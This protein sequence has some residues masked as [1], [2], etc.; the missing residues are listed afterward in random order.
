MW[1]GGGFRGCGWCG[2][3]VRRWFCS[4]APLNVGHVVG[5]FSRIC[6]AVNEKR[7]IN[8]RIY[9]STLFVNNQKDGM[10]LLLLLFNL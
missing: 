7:H 5:F 2:V 8:V 3:G 9:I 6:W 10:S 1:G 4:A